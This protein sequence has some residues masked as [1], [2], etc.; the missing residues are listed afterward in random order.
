MLVY[1]RVTYCRIILIYIVYIC[2]WGL[3]SLLICQW[4]LMNEVLNV[5][6]YKAYM[7]NQFVAAQCLCWADPEKT[8]H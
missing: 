4:L 2:L 3:C 7:G 6:L 1:Q 5:G 8:K